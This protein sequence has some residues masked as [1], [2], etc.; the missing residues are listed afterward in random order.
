MLL[1]TLVKEIYLQ[2][3]GVCIPYLL[4]VFPNL[5]FGIYKYVQVRSIE[6]S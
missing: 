1:D 5:L 2:Y 3:R 4:Q 6:H